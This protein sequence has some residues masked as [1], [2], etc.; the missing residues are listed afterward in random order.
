MVKLDKTN[1][2]SY[3]DFLRATCLFRDNADEL[4]NLTTKTHAH[5]YV[6]RPHLFVTNYAVSLVYCMPFCEEHVTDI[7]RDAREMPVFTRA[8]HNYEVL[9][10]NGAASLHCTPRYGG[11]LSPFLL[12]PKTCNLSPPVE[13]SENLFC[14]QCIYVVCV[15]IRTNSN[16]FSIQH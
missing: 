3:S 12:K 2:S 8:H 1:D 11:W 7:R 16:Y 9:K 5:T 4:R 14:P 6:I 15:D 13:H 10:R